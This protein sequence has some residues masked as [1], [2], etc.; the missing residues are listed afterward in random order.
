MKLL[1]KKNQEIN[2]KILILLNLIINQIIV[3]YIMLRIHHNK[4]L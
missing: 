3:I 4:K 1:I 2:K